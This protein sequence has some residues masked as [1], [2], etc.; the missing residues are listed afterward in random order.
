MADSKDNL[1]LLPMA[2]AANSNQHNIFNVNVLKIIFWNPK[3]DIPIFY[4]DNA[5]DSVKAKLM[6]NQIQIAQTTY[7][8]SDAAT[9]G[10]FKMVLRGWSIDWLNII[11]DT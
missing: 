11:K 8:W 3:A 6:Y 2:R 9:V 1:S 7:H 5:K 4:G 10:N